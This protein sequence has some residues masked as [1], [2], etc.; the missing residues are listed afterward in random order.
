MFKHGLCMDVG[1]VRYGFI[2]QS[3]QRGSGQHIRSP[4]GLMKVMVI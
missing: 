3:Q 4:A 2:A 1:L